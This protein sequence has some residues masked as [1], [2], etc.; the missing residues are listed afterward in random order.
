MLNDNLIF[1]S[2]PW[3]FSN[4]WRINDN[5]IIVYILVVITIRGIMI[6]I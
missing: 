6:T 4:Y 5:Y 3:L 1:V 2:F